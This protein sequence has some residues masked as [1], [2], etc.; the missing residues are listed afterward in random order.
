M[1]PTGESVDEVLG[2]ITSAA[3]RA[4][5]S[6]LCELMQSVSAEQPEVWASRIIGFGTSH[7]RYESGRAGDAPLLG[8]AAQANRFTIYLIGDFQ[9][10][11]ATQLRDLGTYT[12]GKS[13]LYVKRLATGAP[14]LAFFGPHGHS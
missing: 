2:R 13:C 6:T 12:A 10:R 11:H 5:A 14:Y 9:E 1:R 7:Y 8:F 4:E 3:R